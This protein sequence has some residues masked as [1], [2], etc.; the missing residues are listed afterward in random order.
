M[1]NGSTLEKFIYHYYPIWIFKKMPHISTC[2]K[3]S[4]RHSYLEPVNSVIQ[5]ENRMIWLILIM[6]L[7]K[8][9]SKEKSSNKFQ[10][11]NIYN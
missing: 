6:P 10:K 9:Q 8:I 3:Q 2:S 1:K 4:T 11:K 5:T 7:Q